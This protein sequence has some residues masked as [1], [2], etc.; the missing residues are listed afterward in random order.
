MSSGNAIVDMQ[1]DAGMMEGALNRASIVG[2]Q[3]RSV[4]ES[5]DWCG[6]IENDEF[7]WW[8]VIR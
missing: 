4:G 2:A 3:F 6:G 8:S 5:E 7:E 1:A